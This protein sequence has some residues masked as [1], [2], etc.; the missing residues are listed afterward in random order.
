MKGEPGQKGDR[1][2]LGLPVSKDNFPFQRASQTFLPTLSNNS[3]L[4]SDYLIVE[5]S[6][7]GEGLVLAQSA[8][9]FCLLTSAPRQRKT[10]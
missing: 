10:P 2:P 1:G 4:L 7:V 3:S 6:V 5:I 9:Q 8:A